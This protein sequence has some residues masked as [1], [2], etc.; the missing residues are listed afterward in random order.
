MAKTSK[1]I[2][3][4]SSCGAEQVKWSGR[5]SECKEYNTITEMSS[6]VSAT[7]KGGRKSWTGQDSKKSRMLNEV[8]AG[9][10]KNR[11]L[12]HI[13]E[14]DRVLGGG[15]VVGSMVLIGGDP[16][17]GKSTLL[18]QAADAI[19]AQPDL[20]VLYV[21]GEE[22]LEQV[23]ARAIRLGLDPSRVRGLAETHVEEIQRVADEYKPSLLI[24]D[25][26][27]TLF[28]ETIQSAPGTVSQVRECAAL[29]T[30]QSKQT[31]MATILVGHVT[32]DG[33]IA[34][35]RVLEHMVD[36]VLAFEGDPSSPYRL[37]RAPKNRFGAANEMGAF[38]MKEDGLHSVD[39]PS[40]L[41]LS[42]DRV[43]SQ[44]SCV[45][46]LQEGPRPM[47]VEIQALLDDTQTSNPKRLAVGVD[48]NRLNM[49][50][51]ILHRHMSVPSAQYDAF[52]SAVGGIKATEPAADLSIILALMSSLRDISLPSDLCCFGEVGLTGEVRPVQMSESRLRE[53]IKLGFTKLLIPYRNLPSKPIPGVE[54][55]GV[56]NLREAFAQ[57]GEWELLSKR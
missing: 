12:T 8:E 57:S 50:L 38:E 7:G 44:G 15:I 45:A 17:V 32:K 36:A 21:T 43:P 55:I 18:L 4:C 6:D 30:R 53:A 42:D 34:G 23:A 31:G 25:S 54:I 2:F 20:S 35:P 51:A 47:L 40:A 11:M 22:S 46:V 13:G 33:T 49:L 29:L 48:N 1:P 37:I 52:V 10:Q 26:I 9:A 39:N 14:F 56:K 5:C 41:F 3:V 24:A 19:G 27:Q 16:G 28:T